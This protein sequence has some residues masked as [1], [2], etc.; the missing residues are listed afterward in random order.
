MISLWGMVM[1]DDYPIPNPNPNPGW[2]PTYIQYTTTFGDEQPR[3]QRKIYCGCYCSTSL[4]MLYRWCAMWPGTTPWLQ[5][6]LV[7]LYI[8]RVLL[9]FWWAC[10]ASTESG[11]SPT[12]IPVWTCDFYGAK[13]T[14]MSV[15]TS[16]HAG[17]VHYLPFEWFDTAFCLVFESILCY[18]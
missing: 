15:D 3:T 8:W 5:L 14:I 9:A 12:G 4:C 2:R 11:L 10:V 18:L 13:N 6:V 1:Y 7:L 17:T 16:F